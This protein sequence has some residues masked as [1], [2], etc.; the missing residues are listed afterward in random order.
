MILTMKILELINKKHEYALTAF[1]SQ[2]PEIE[3]NRNIMMYA[4][5]KPQPL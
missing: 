3:G 5:P 4:S 2:L 1:K